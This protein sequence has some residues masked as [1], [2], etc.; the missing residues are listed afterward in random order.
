MDYFLF[1]V[2]GISFY[3]IT[4]L[5]VFYSGCS[6]KT[7]PLFELIPAEK[8][9]VHFSNILTETPE[10]NIFNYLYFYDGGGVAAGDVNGDG[11]PDLYFTS[12]QDS[13]RLYLNKGNFE[14]EDITVRS[15]VWGQIGWTNGVSMVDVNGDN[16][17]DMYV[18]QLGEFG[19]IGGRNQL[20][21]NQGNSEQGVPVFVDEAATWGLDL[22]GLSTQAAFFDYDLDGDL[23]M[24]MLNHSV[25]S[26]GTFVRSEAREIP[27]ELAGDRLMKN[28]GDHFVDVSQEAGIYQSVIGYGLGIAISDIN[29]DGY[30]DIFVGNDFHEDDYLY[31]NNGDGTFTESLGKSI[32]HTSKSSMGND[33]ADFNNDGF[34]DIISVDMLPYDPVLLKT[35]E[36]E[37]PYDIYVNKLAYGYKHQLARNTLQLNL[38]N[39]TFSE[40]AYLAGVP[41]TDW[42]WSG[43]FV[44]L[45]LDG[46]KDIYLSNGIKRRSND[47]DYI[48][49]ISNDAIQRRLKGEMTE[50]ELAYA[51]KM[52]EVK[53]QNFAFH[54]NRDLTFTNVAGDWGMGQPSFSNGAVYADL[55]GDGDLDM[56]VNNIEDK[57]F[58]FKNNTINGQVDQPNFLKVELKGEGLNTKG[59]GAKIVIP[60]SDQGTIYHEVFTSRGFLSSVD[61]TVIIGLGNAKAID[62][63]IVIWPDRRY[64]SLTNIDANQKLII[65]QKNARGEYDYSMTTKPIFS[66][67]EI[68]G[69]DYQHKENRPIE[70]YR[71]ILLPQMTSTEGPCMMVGDVDGDGKEDIILSGAKMQR[72][73]VYLQKEDGFSLSGQRELSRDS[74]CEDTA[75]ELVDVDLDGDLDLLIASGGNEF[76]LSDEPSLVRL[77]KNDGLGNFSRDRASF[78]EIFV[79]GS[80]IATHDVN[81]DGY[82]DFFIGARAVPRSYGEIPRSYLLLSDGKGKW[83]DETEKTGGVNLANVGMVKD[84]KWV[85]IDNDEDEDLIVV[86]EWMAPMIFINEKDR[87]VESDEANKSF[88]DKNGFWNN[89]EVVDVDGDSDLDLLTGNLGLN[90][91][92]QSSP[93][94]PVEMFVKDF[95]QNGVMDQIV[96]HYVLGQKYLLPTRDELVQQL[97]FMDKKFPTYREFSQAEPDDFFTE[98]EL[99]SAH[100]LVAEELRSGVFLN[101]GNLQFEFRPF[102]TLAQVSPITSIYI[103]DYDSDGMED[104]LVAGNEFN[105]SIQRGRYD[106]NRGLLLRN[107]GEVNFEPVWNDRSGLNLT[108]QVR[109]MKSIDYQGKRLILIAINNEKI[110]ILEKM[111]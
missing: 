67:V 27:N 41:A 36:G 12:N 14:F 8:S 48:T 32:E 47:M 43:L 10:M 49:F 31:L 13:N 24:Y 53:V 61:P 101:Q 9:G 82:P 55:D 64:E 107:A 22:K 93:K 35:A 79:M 29:K 94:E 34:Q 19:N 21:I 63:L 110:R 51:E 1:P 11:L 89:V 42:S 46:W 39:N 60:N 102:P 99:A 18:S 78:P 108:G 26:L 80:C 23:D 28:E 70:I 6:R 86:G 50:A 7:D 83:L 58:I 57:A 90:S 95:D 111:D 37:D 65:D 66:E 69:L 16:R 54:N 15:G 30:P 77:Y 44:D 59:I 4:I 87:L 81:R 45:D 68:E 33:I 75:V 100:R 103:L 84:A 38:G 105:V 2:K 98:K 85:D 109:E 96:F 71:E 106:A 91:I 72:T 62:S 73:A 88:K 40:I 76:R 56:V 97:G 52:P 104:I 74:L 25:H 5:I 20:F 3:V 92:F 17:L